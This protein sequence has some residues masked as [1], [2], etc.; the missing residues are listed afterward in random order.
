MTKTFIYILTVFSILTTYGQQNCT[1]IIDVQY[2]KSIDI[3]DK[4][5]GKTIHQMSNDSANEDFI[6]IKI[7][8]EKSSF[9]YVFINKNEKKDSSTGWIKK[10]DYVGAFKRNETN[11][12]ELILYKKK[13]ASDRDKISIKSWTPSFLTIEKCVGNWTFVSL[14]RSGE[15]IKGWIQSNELCANA[16]TYCN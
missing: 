15:I 6:N 1:A 8:S 3:Y 13:N 4:P 9:F 10:A 14:R 2:F 5:F 11:P 16:Y 12:M 7:L